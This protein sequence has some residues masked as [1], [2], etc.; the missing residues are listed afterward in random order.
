M[1]SM[2]RFLCPPAPDHAQQE[3][4]TT[5]WG[6]ITA[7]WRLG[8]QDSAKCQDFEMKRRRTNHQAIKNLPGSQVSNA[9]I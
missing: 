4:K 5:C 1:K 3:Y 8:K 6:V 2:G 9:N 7:S